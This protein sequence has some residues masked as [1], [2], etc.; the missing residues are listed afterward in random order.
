LVEDPR[1]EKLIGQDR[2]MAQRRFVVC[3]IIPG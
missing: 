2:S 1:G 3:D